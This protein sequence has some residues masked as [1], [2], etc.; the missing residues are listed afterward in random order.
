MIMNRNKFTPINQLEL[1][2]AQFCLKEIPIDEFYKAFI[3]ST[4]YVI[5]PKKP[6]KKVKIHTADENTEMHYYGQVFNGKPYVLIFSSL[7]RIQ[8]YLGLK[9]NEFTAIGLKSRDF[10][11]SLGKED[12]GLLLNLGSGYGKEFIPSEIQTLLMIGCRMG[13]WK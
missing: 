13:H 2:L 1:I 6:P 12:Q 5:T 8:D 11:E 3:H 10:L 4:I 9:I 7:E